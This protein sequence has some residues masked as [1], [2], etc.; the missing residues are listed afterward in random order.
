MPVETE[1]PGIMNLHVKVKEKLTGSISVGGGYSSDDGLFTSAQIMQR[2]LFGKGESVSIRAYL[3]QAAQRYI[4]SFTEPWMF[5]YPVAGGLDVY[6]WLRDYDQFT[7]ESVG[8][9]LRV[10]KPF[11]LHSRVFAYYTFEQDRVSDVS[12]D[13]SSYI[14]SQ[15][16]L[17][18]TT[19]SSVT[20]GA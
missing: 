18:W 19:L 16:D 4:F 2:N 9:R 15:A 1:Q 10:G 14:R 17:G 5:G 11:G 7:Q 12:S 3:G 8:F 13:A 6:N 20:V